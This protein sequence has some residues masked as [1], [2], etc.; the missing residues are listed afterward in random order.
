VPL[1]FEWDER[2]ARLNA[3]KHRVTFSEGTTVFGDPL[4]LTIADPDHSTREH[5]FLTVGL[6]RSGGLL[7]VSHTDREDRTRIISVRRATPRERRAY[8]GQ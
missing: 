2:K 5:R 4:S 6:G 3:L 8:E 1:V 7:V